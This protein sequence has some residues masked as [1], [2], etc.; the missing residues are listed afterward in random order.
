MSGS[1]T[2]NTDLDRSTLAE[3][4]AA[5][6]AIALHAAGT[7]GRQGRAQDAHRRQAALATRENVA[8][9]FEVM[10]RIDVDEAVTSYRSVDGVA[11]AVS[12]GF[13][14]DQAGC[15]HAR[16]NQ[17]AWKTARLESSGEVAIETQ[18]TMSGD[19]LIRLA[20]ALLA[21]I[22]Q[23]ATTRSDASGKLVFSVSARTVRHFGGVRDATLSLLS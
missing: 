18:V 15:A 21:D 23:S 10:R 4:E 22:K 1:G 7:G 8:E 3:N 20:K 2:G 19:L 13:R 11:L 5:G 14:G 12:L 17:A 9:A 16:W 6:G